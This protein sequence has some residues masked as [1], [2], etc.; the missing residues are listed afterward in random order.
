MAV[1]KLINHIF[2]ILQVT[3]LEK[4]IAGGKRHYSTLISMEM[5]E[6]ILVILM[7]VMAMNLVAIIQQHF[8]DLEQ[9]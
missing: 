7:Q 9:L 2:N 6:K 8:Q 1:L 5:E 4:I 3:L